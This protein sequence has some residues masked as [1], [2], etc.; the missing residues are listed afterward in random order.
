[1]SHIIRIKL[2]FNSFDSYD[3]TSSVPNPTKLLYKE[4]FQIG[5]KS[6]YIEL[7]TSLNKFK[8]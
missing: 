3:K 5:E 1:M 4:Y 7:F 2:F 6:L 8:G